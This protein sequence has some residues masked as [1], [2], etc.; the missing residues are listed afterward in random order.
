VFLYKIK[1]GLSK[2]INDISMRKAIVFLMS[3]LIYWLILGSSLFAQSWEELN[4]KVVEYYQKGDFQTAITYAEKVVVQAE[5]EF[6]KEHGNYATSLNNLA[7]LYYKIGDYM[8][9]E[10]LYLEALKIR[11][12][13]LG[14]NHSDYA[15][16]LIGLAV[17]YKSMGDYTKAEPLYL[18]AS[19]IYK[20]TLGENHPSYAASLNNLAGLYRAMGDYTKAEPLYL[21]ALKITKQ[22]FGENHPDYAASLN[23]LAGL[24]RAMGDYTKA[25]PLYLEA[26]KIKKQ[27]HGENHP[28]YAAFL[29]NLS[30]LYKAM[31]DYSKA[32]P[33]YL[34]ALE[35]IK[36]TLGVNHP[37]YAASLNN[38][39]SLYDDM[40]DYTKAEPLYLEASKIYKQALGEDHP[41]YATS[42]DNLAGLYQSICDYTKAEPL[43]LEALKIKKETLRVNHPSYGTSLNNLALLYYDMGDYTKAEPLY[44][45]ALKIK[46]ETLGVNHPSYATSLNNLAVLY[47]NMGNYSKS[48]PLMTEANKNYLNQIETYFP[49]LSENEKAKFLKTIDYKFEVFYSFVLKYQKEIPQIT[50]EMLN[51]RLAS[52]GVILSSMNRIRES[53]EKSGDE[54]LKSLSRNLTETQK[55]L[56]NASLLSIEEQKKR[57]LDYAQLEKEANDLGK[58]LAR[59]SDPFKKLLEEKN[60]TFKEIEKNLSSDEAAVEFLNFQYYDK[61]WTDTTYYTALITRPGYKAPI[62]VKLCTEDE[63]GGI[64]NFTPD[65]VLRRPKPINEGKRNESLT[66]RYTSIYNLIWKPLEQYLKGCK[67]VYISPSGVLNKVSFAALSKDG[68][69]LLIDE[70]KLKYVGNLRDIVTEK[71]ENK[72][73]PINNAVL[74]GGAI[75]DAEPQNLKNYQRSGER[76][77]SR[78]MVNPFSY[79]NSKDILVGDNS[80]SVR[81]NIWNNLPG[82]IKEVNDISLILQNRNIAVTLDT[83]LYANEQNLKNLSGRNDAGILHISTHGFFIIDTAKEDTKT[84]FRMTETKQISRI[85]DNPLYRSGI[86]LSGAS[87]AATEE[88]KSD[89]TENG[90]ITAYEISLMDLTGTELV[91]LSAC[92]T[93]LGDIRGGEGVYG[94]QRAFKT[95]GAKNVIM[96]LWKVPDAETAELMKMFYENWLTKGMEKREA[97]LEAQKEM[98]KLNP[99]PFFWA[100]FVMM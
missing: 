44:L 30:G 82:T 12:Q 24:Y 63:L 40:G 68:S 89:T 95:T 29:N 19:K 48:K 35:I 31:G 9:A 97:L 39:A 36:Q 16:S 64:M 1:T 38:L 88:I 91:V 53:V 72:Q 87:T 83:G 7:L 42:L 73:L 86:V 3:F 90:I 93:G 18:E 21:E 70:T 78:E 6:G 37:S 57:G 45:E 33:L 11:K 27:A 28:D 8:K 49:I 99:N 96:S 41:D 13:V 74:F 22:A 65:E 60:I 92:E 77:V 51:L 26:L 85:L 67:T 71:N 47:Y 23:N 17:L 100:A 20:Q 14:E 94:L 98:R 10:P 54:G 61:K 84:I 15:T 76:S 56:Y 25:E 62:L 52:K 55:K 34:E 43:Y 69:K 81:G 79:K 46:K 58:E 75:F 5:K 2:Y 50:E 4:S 32:E 59:K 80:P 66:E